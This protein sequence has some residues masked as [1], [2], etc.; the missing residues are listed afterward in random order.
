MLTSTIYVGDLGSPRYIRVT[1]REVRAQLRAW[2]V[3]GVWSPA[4][5]G[6]SVRREHL[7]DLRA[8]CDLHGV[9]LVERTGALS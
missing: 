2:S 3:P 9:R 8:L 7:A 5:R 1:G 6:V 4:E